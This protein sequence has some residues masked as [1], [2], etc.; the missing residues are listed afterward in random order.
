MSATQFEDWKLATA[1]SMQTG[2]LDAPAG[3][4][5]EWAAEAIVDLRHVVAG[6]TFALIIEGVF[7]F[8]GFSVW[9]FLRLWHLW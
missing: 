9:H 7:A 2:V 4:K 8:A 3:P 1:A 6:I 5:A